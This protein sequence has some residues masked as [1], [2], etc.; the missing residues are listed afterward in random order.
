MIVSALP[1]PR[2]KCQ[3]DPALVAEAIGKHA[4]RAERVVFETDPL[5]ASIYHA[6][7]ARRVPTICIDTR[8]A[9]AALDIVPNKTD[10]NDADGLAHLA[11]V[12]FYRKAR[13]KADDS[14]LTRT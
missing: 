5:S 11:E 3:S 6:L 12:G 14:M 2:G 4:P 8:H 7:M 10:P 13:V 1:P 9:K